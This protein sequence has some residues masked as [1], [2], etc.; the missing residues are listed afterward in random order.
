[1]VPLNIYRLPPLHPVPGKGSQT[2][3]IRGTM[4]LW[5]PK[6][7]GSMG[8]RR[9]RPLR[10]FGP[11]LATGAR[12][13]LFLPGL[14]SL[15]TTFGNRIQLHNAQK[16]ATI[17]TRQ[18]LDCN[19]GWR[20]TTTLPRAHQ[21]RNRRPRLWI[22]EMWWGTAPPPRA[23][24]P[25]RLCDV[26]MSQEGATRSFPPRTLQRWNTFQRHPLST[27]LKRPSNAPQTHELFI[28]P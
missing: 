16:T 18:T 5:D 21:T 22:R 15:T 9:P 12:M 17:N 24:V 13:S 3:W 8:P 6:D 28:Q 19:P 10:L 14:A 23:T 27:L 1:M 11:L 7:H 4:H 2:P 20:T 26:G 25:R